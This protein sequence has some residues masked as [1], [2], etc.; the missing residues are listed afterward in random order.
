M[1]YTRGS[2]DNLDKWANVTGDKELSWDNMFSYMLKV[3]NYIRF[4]GQLGLY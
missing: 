2:R 1:V 4:T 3:G